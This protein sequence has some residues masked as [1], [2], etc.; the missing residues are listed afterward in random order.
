MTTTV[1]MSQQAVYDQISA[2][3]D[4]NQPKKNVTCHCID[5]EICDKK[6]NTCR[7]TEEHQRCYQSWRL[8]NKNTIQLNAGFVR[9][10]SI[11]HLIIMSKWFLAACTMM[12]FMFNCSA[13]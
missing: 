11:D 6:T 5:D 10:V 2:I 8:G 9:N 7:L 13:D 3:V 1:V 12:T 4:G